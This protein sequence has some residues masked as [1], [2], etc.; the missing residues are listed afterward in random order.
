M[1]FRVDR[2]LPMPVRQ[3]LKGTIAFGIAFGE[4]AVGSAL[5]S[6]REMAALAGIAPMTVSQVYSELKEE[7]LIETRLGSGTFIADS[8]QARAAQRTDIDVLHRQIDAMI[9]RADLLGVELTDLAAMINA[10]IAYRQRPGRRVSV[11]MAGLF[12]DATASYADFIAARLGRGVA[13]EPV[14]LE[15]LRQRPDL[16]AQAC[17]ADFVVTFS[18]RHGEVLDL[19]PTARV[20]TLRFIPS[21]STRMALAS[22]DPTA[23][24]LVLSRFPDFLPI[25][26][27]GVQRFASHVAD[28]AA[29]NF[30][31]P[32]A[33]DHLAHCD[34][35]VY[36]TGT[37]TTAEL[38]GPVV[39][40]F[41]YR[42]IPDP[43]DVDRVLKPLVEGSAAAPVR[44]KE[45]A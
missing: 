36:A 17:S 16:R 43:A 6:V 26:R 27:S 33:A 8:S 44:L 42:H 10:R 32:H 38:A 12:P 39:H 45:I 3:Q 15:Q 2:T 34:V 29:I 22:I 7:G 18:N 5:P 24:V 31:D 40:K 35:V 23:R 14:T 1:D 20:V 37:E 9:D 21:E 28:V 30:D 19:L 11:V 4:L 25:F 13:V 41:E